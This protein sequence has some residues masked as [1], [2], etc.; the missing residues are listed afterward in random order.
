MASDDILTHFNFVSKTYDAGRD[1]TIPNFE[2]FYQ[3]GIEMLEFAGDAP[4]ILDIG[5]G[6][7]LFSAFILEKFPKAELT[8]IDFSEE[9]LALAKQRFF[10]VDKVRYILADY[11]T[12]AYSETY[13]IVIS[14]L[15]I[16][17]LSADDKA[18]FYQTAYHLLNPS[19]EFINADLTISKYPKIQDKLIANWLAFAMANGVS[20]DY[21]LDSM[22]IDDPS[23]V[24][25]QLEWLENAGF[26]T[27]DCV[28]KRDHFAVFYADKK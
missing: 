4:K 1:K 26:A 6:S 5:A 20:R 12:Y 15:S 27:V 3:S 11:S 7:G 28:H 21:L 17:H 9:M 24:G 14:A 19:G 10:G 25:E 2:Q 8:L 23:T 18:K 16:H 22:K 13:D